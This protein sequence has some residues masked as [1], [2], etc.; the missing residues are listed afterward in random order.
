MGMHDTHYV[1]STGGYILFLPIIHVLL[2]II[3]AIFVYPFSKAFIVGIASAR[4]PSHRLTPRSAWY[5]F[6]PYWKQAFALVCNI[7]IPIVLIMVVLMSLFSGGATGV[8]IVCLVLLLLILFGSIAFALLAAFQLSPRFSS[9]AALTALSVIIAAIEC[10][11]LQSLV[12]VV[13]VFLFASS[14]YDS[15]LMG[16]VATSPIIAM[17]NWFLF[18]LTWRRIRSGPAYEWF[19]FES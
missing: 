13:C 16:L 19:R 1:V 11:F 6:D 17:A 3:S 2:T 8:V 10:I 14:S 4:N 5:F 7:H 12:L 18:S 9:A 15:A